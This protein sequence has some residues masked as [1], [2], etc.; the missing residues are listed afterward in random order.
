MT[1]AGIKVTWFVCEK[2]ATSRQYAVTRLLPAQEFT[3]SPE[4]KKSKISP[5]NQ[6]EHEKDRHKVKNEL[7]G[8][9]PEDAHRPVRTERSEKRH[10]KQG[11]LSGSPPIV[12]R[13]LL[14]MGVEKKRD[15]IDQRIESQNEH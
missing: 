15:K 6:V 7:S 9:V 5:D 13:L 11:T 12:S 4:Y 8:L 10:D 14:V 3:Y 1:D 2:P